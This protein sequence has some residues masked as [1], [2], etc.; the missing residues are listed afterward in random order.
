M[1]EINSDQVIEINVKLIW[2]DKWLY[3]LKKN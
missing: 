1:V 2:I 3:A